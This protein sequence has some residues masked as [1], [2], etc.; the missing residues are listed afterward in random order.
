MSKHPEQLLRK[1]LV[2]FDRICIRR[3]GQKLSILEPSS[4]VGGA[5]TAAHARRCST[6]GHL[7]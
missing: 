1:V 4:K 7:A 6:R 5:A 3:E 2:V